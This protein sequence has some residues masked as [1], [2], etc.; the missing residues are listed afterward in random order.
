[1]ETSLLFLSYT[2]EAFLTEDIS[3]NSGASISGWF[4]LLWSLGY[5]HAGPHV[6]GLQLNP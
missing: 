5:Q 6:M 1:M 3:K 4:P 2:V